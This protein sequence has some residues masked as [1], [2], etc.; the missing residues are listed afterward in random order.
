MLEVS[1]Y[2]ARLELETA[3]TLLDKFMILLSH[4]PLP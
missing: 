3:A 2:G 4:A 1:A